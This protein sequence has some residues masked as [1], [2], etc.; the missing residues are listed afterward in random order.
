[1][2]I[3]LSA[4]HCS[5]LHGSELATGWNWVLELS[6]LGHELT[7]ITQ[8]DMREYVNSVEPLPNVEFNYVDL[9]DTKLRKVSGYLGILRAY[10]RWQG[11][12]LALIRSRE[13]EFDVAHHVTWGGL[14]LGSGLWP[15]STPLIFGP[16]GS[17]QVPPSSYRGYFGREWQNERLRGVLGGP[18]LKANRRAA[19]HGNA[20]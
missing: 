7:I 15:L 12:A 13:R 19:N 20:A 11:D 16:V 3:L 5:P 6:N 4:F 14:H 18:L 1:M 9:P 8:A 2:R 17:G 10:T